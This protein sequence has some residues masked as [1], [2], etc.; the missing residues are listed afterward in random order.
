MPRKNPQLSASVPVET[1]ELLRSVSKVTGQS[2]S[3]VV[4]ELIE[5][6]VPHLKLVVEAHAIAQDRREELPFVMQG[7]LNDAAR[8]LNDAQTEMS[9]VWNKVRRQRRPQ[10]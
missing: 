6:A 5:V 10:E 1:Y 2:L 4:A 7:I 9:E 8:Q 3:S